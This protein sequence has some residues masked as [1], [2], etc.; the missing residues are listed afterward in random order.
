MKV[1][2]PWILLCAFLAAPFVA[3]A[4]DVARPS[5]GNQRA[6]N[7]IAATTVPASRYNLKVGP[8]KML[9]NAGI[10]AEYNTNV[11]VSNENPEPDLILTP[12]IGMGVY[13]PMTK[14]NKLRCNVQVGYQYYLNNPDLNQ[15][16]LIVDPGT[17]F[18][19]NLF[20]NVPNIR[21]T[22]FDRPSITVNPV[23]DPTVSNTTNYAIFNNTAGIDLLWDLNDVQIGLGYNNFIQYA[24]NQDFDYTNRVSNQA[25]GNVSF[26]VL[27][28]LRLGLEGSATGTI[29]TAGDAPGSSALNNSIGYTL[30]LF[31]SGQLSRYVEW[32]AGVG[33]QL[34]DFNESNNPLNTG[35]YS[36]P[37]YYLSIDHALNR[38]FNHRIITGLEATPSTE[39]NYMQLFY[40]RYSFNWLLLND[41][42]LGG[43]AFFENGNESPGPN[44]ENFNRV[45]ATVGLNYQ[46]T[47]HWMLN[48]YYGVLAKGSSVVADSYGQQRLGLNV[49][50]A[51]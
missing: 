14:L 10:G 6:A 11:N 19:F 25:Y 32:K 43:T 23:D 47:K 15:Q 7:P 40:I 51:F 18:M 21:I 20:L 50:Y 26:L 5:L 45:G 39:S 36:D 1:H 2:I 9:F 46:L 3:L 38:Y 49:N 22:F 12:R 44:S 8:V 35:N 16:T 17:E 24:I 30:G 27:P 31:A 41:W 28:Y 33:W 4:Q 34:T 29:Y 13:W 48:V 42:S 37:Y